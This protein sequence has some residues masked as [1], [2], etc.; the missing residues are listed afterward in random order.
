MSE[1][2]YAFIGAGNMSGAILG[3][4]VESGIDANSIMATNRTQE[5]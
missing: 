4:M 5:K 1:T 2:K 3:G